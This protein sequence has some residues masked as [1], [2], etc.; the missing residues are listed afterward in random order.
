MLAASLFVSVTAANEEVESFL[1]PIA[2]GKES[3]RERKGEGSHE[4]TLDV[5]GKSTST[6]LQREEI[7][8]RGAKWEREERHESIT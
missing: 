1:Q 6:E 4:F 5:L 3:G 2:N 7:E 8:E